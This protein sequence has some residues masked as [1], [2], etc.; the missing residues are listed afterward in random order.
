MYVLRMN[1]ARHIPSFGP[2]TAST[3][4]PSTSIGFDSRNRWS[5]MYCLKCVTLSSDMK[6]SI[7]TNIN[8]KPPS[9]NSP[10]PPSSDMRPMPWNTPVG[11]SPFSPVK[12]MI[13]VYT[14]R[15]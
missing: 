6:T 14:P 12:C 7:P 4:S 1:E 11:H 8:V 9:R 3:S 15:L 2:S 10:F 13:S 5:R